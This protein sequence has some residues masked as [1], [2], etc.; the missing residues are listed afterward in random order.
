MGIVSPEKPS[1]ILPVSGA[2]GSGHRSHLIKQSFCF[3]VSCP[4]QGVHRDRSFV[5]FYRHPWP[6]V[7]CLAKSYAWSKGMDGWMER[8]TNGQLGAPAREWEGNG[9][10]LREAWER[11]W[12][13]QRVWEGWKGGCLLLVEA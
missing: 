9:V 13:G 4:E 8:W 10:G 3:S 11:P 2:L 5:R 7:Q 6:R 12:G 1:P